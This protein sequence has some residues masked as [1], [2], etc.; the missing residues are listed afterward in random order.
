MF[1]GERLLTTDNP[2]SDADRALFERLGLRFQTTQE[3]IQDTTV[4]IFDPARECKSG[5]AAA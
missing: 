3:I 4:K 2:D 1:Y 5:Q